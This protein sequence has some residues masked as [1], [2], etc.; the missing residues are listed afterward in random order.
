[1]IDNVHLLKQGPQLG[2]VADIAARK[3]DIRPERLWIARGKVV[4]PAH[5]VSLAGEMVGK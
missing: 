4:Q 2:A 5:L 1:V 3:M